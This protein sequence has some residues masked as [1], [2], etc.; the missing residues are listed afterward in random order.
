MPHWRFLTLIQRGPGRDGSGRSATEAWLSG[1]QTTP[2]QT[3]LNAF[4]ASIF[5]TIFSA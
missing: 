2:G 4:T 3:P 1:D 5:G